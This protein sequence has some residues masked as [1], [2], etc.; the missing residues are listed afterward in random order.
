[1]RVGEF[2]AAVV[3]FLVIVAQPELLDKLLAAESW[4]RSRA[5]E[6]I[7]GSADDTGEGAPWS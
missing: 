5:R 6:L 2:D 4:A 7:S 3:F 1:M